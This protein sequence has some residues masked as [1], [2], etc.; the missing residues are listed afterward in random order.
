MTSYKVHFEFWVTFSIKFQTQ[1]FFLWSTDTSSNTDSVV[2]PSHE[3]GIRKGETAA[4][5]IRRE[6]PFAFHDAS[7]AEVACYAAYDAATA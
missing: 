6:G 2:D 5:G 4:A 1:K 7:C 3:G